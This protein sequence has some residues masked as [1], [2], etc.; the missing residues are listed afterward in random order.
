MNYFTYL[1][2]QYRQYVPKRDEGAEVLVLQFGEGLDFELAHAENVVGDPWQYYIAWGE[3]ASGTERYRATLRSAVR[4]LWKGI[5]S[6][7]QFVDNMLASTDRFMRMAFTEGTRSCGIQP[8]EWSDA[9]RNRLLGAIVYE[10][11]WIT[12][13]ATT[14]ENVRR[15]GGKLTPLF[16]RLEIW[17][18]RYEGLRDEA[19]AMAC[20]DRKFMWVRGATEGCSSCIK[21]HGKI[22]RGSWW[23]ENGVLPRVHGSPLLLCQGFRCQCRLVPTDLPLSR[24]PMPGLP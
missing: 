12:G 6:Y 19:A 4:G 7:D 22:K 1:G 8:D 14:V 20:A 2:Q 11:Q 16:T 9:E 18:G 17:A 13:L 3:K 15:D 10:R 24:G 21:L 5:I 23:T